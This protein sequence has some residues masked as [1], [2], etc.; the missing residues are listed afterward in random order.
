MC[1]G[2]CVCVACSPAFFMHLP[3]VPLPPRPSPWPL[4]HCPLGPRVAQAMNEVAQGRVWTGR[5]AL[6]RSLVDEIGGLDKALELAAELAER[7]APPQSAKVALG[8]EKRVQT[9]R[10]PRSGLPFPFAGGASAGQGVGAGGAGDGVLA[11]CDEAVACTGLVSPR[12]LGVGPAVASL[13]LGPA[14]AYAL[15]HSPAGAAVEAAAAL[16]AQAQTQWWAGA[17]AAVGGMLRVV[18]EELL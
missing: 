6:Q 10:E 14:V 7:S 3:C 1:V 4:S 5:Q 9:L 16:A 12:V 18:D 17:V 15:A 13:G 2:V 8:G 11:L